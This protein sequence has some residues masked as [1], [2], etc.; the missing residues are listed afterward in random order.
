MEKI[1]AALI[2][3]ACLVLLVRMLLRPVQRQRLDAFARRTWGAL[4]DLPNWR[5][6]RQQR[7]QAERDAQAAIERAQR[8]SQMQQDVDWDGNVARPKNF[9]DRGKLH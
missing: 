8:R 3:L 1:P 9:R 6:R 5:V 7:Q 2:L 4:K